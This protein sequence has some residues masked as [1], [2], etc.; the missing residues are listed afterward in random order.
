MIKHIQCDIFESGADII[1]HQV[2]C[3]GV[4]N[5]G[6]AKQV[7]NKYPKVYKEYKKLYNEAKEDK[8]PLLG[9]VQA[10]RINDDNPFKYIVNIFSQDN[11][12]YDNKCYTNY[13]ILKQSFTVIKEWFED[14]VIAIPYKIGCIR[15]GGD[16]NIVY[17]MIEE[18]FNNSDCKVLICEYNGG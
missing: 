10:V 12:G 1:C 2:N 5:S 17:K 9:C 11:Y 3:Q 16:W 6:I 15:G 18:V 8:E 13:E 7:K 14:R 4:M